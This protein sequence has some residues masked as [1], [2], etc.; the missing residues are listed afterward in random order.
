MLVLFGSQAKT[1]SFR[2]P[3]LLSAMLSFSRLRVVTVT[4][5]CPTVIQS[6]NPCFGRLSKNLHKKLE[7]DV[8]Q[9]LL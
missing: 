2:V 6:G 1:P 4:K 8:R 9:V 5:R 7:L 3:I